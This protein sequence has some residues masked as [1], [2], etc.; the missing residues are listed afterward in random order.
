MQCK[1]AVHS[2]LLSMLGILF[3]ASVNAQNLSEVYVSAE[4][5]L[6]DFSKVILRDLVIQGA[7]II[8]PVWVEGEDRDPHKW[9]MSKKNVGLLK[10]GFQAAIKEKLEENGGYPVVTDES[11]GVLEITVELISLIPYVQRWEKVITRGTGE[12]RIQVTLR[13]A[14]TG[15]LL[16]IYEGNQ[17]V[18]DQYQ[19][20]TDL[21]SLKDAQDLFV[22]WGQK[23]R[24][25]LDDAHG[26]NVDQ[27]E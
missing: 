24:K 21:A 14:M 18:G 4:A 27:A 15:A 7:Q 11:D 9:I 3:C 19:E 6:S 16:A 2:L 10:E 25:A 23:I 12:I 5:D 8:P 20:N 26:T 1:R 17:K 13:N 22:V